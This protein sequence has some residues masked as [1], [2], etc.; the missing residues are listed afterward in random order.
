MSFAHIFLSAVFS[1]WYIGAGYCVA[2]VDRLSDRISILGVVIF[3]IFGLI[4]FFLLKRRFFVGRPK[5][6]T[7]RSDKQELALSDLE[8]RLKKSL[9]E[10]RRLTDE[11]DNFLYTISHDLRTPVGIIR[12]YIDII[13]SDYMDGLDDELATLL[14][15]VSGNAKKMERLIDE[16]V[17]LSRLTGSKMDFSDTDIYKLIQDS[18]D[19]MGSDKNRVVFNILKIPSV[20]CDKTKFFDL[21]SRL[22]D[23]AV[24]FS[25]RI[26]SE[27]TSVEIGYSSC[28][29]FHK[30]YVRDNGIGIGSEYHTKIFDLFVKLHPDDRYDGTGSGLAIVKKIVKLHGGEVWVDSVSGEGATFYFT[31][32]KNLG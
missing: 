32:S 16:L 20:R 3:I 1:P 9:N 24:K 11:M 4:S 19:K 31:I 26:E 6:R 17:V 23:N 30:F 18:V 14:S 12:S 5:N 21:I 27:K 7:D 22:I 10:Q 15:R 13:E 2:S 28:D 25:S 29:K 8:S